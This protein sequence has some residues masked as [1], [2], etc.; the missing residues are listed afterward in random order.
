[1]LCVLLIR[2]G[3]VPAGPTEREVLLRPA[4]VALLLLL[5]L[6]LA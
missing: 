2:L 5:L 6:L 4:P 3:A 1:L